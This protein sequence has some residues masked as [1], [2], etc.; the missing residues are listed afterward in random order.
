M[1]DIDLKL[2]SLLADNEFMPT[3]LCLSLFVRHVALPP[4]S[5]DKR[6]RRGQPDF[7]ESLRVCARV[8]RVGKLHSRPEG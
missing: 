4:M 5:R 1:K 6:R 8:H 7:L 3:P 2:S